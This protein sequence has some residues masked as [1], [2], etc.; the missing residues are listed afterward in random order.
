MSETLRRTA[1]RPKG[2]E[3]SAMDGVH[4][5]RRHA[6]AL[7]R[8]GM[9]FAFLSPMCWLEFCFSLGRCLVPSGRHFKCA[10]DLAVLKSDPGTPASIDKSTLAAVFSHA[11]SAVDVQKWHLNKV[12]N[13]V[14][15]LI[16][17][18][19]CQVL[20]REMIRS[21]CLSHKHASSER[22]QLRILRRVSVVGVETLLAGECVRVCAHVCIGMCY[23]AQPSCGS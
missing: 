20:I 11:F 14:N 9:K 12:F 3:S 4:F 5:T 8:Q 1:S 2:V 17:F 22:F 19:S 15:R 21:V 18:H 23:Q 7:T 13:A 6:L 10:V 16:F